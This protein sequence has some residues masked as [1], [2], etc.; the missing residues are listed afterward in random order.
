MAGCKHRVKHGPFFCRSVGMFRMA[1]CVKQLCWNPGCEKQNQPCD[2]GHSGGLLITAQK[3]GLF[4]ELLSI[5]AFQTQSKHTSQ[6][7]LSI[8]SLPRCAFCPL[9]ETLLCKCASEN[10]D[11]CAVWRCSLFASAV[12]PSVTV[13]GIIAV[14][15][16]SNVQASNYV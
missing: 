13:E 15:I 16:V 3:A 12:V 11:H 5:T 10:E 8:P 14:K 1:N 6:Q 4:I 9:V 2:N 7:R